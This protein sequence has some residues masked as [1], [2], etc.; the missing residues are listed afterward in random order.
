MSAA[1][2]RE[3]EF[4]DSGKLKIVSS[5]KDTYIERYTKM[6]RNLQ[7]IA[8][9]LVLLITIV[10][11]LNLLDSRTIL[12]ITAIGFITASF[13]PSLLAI[14]GFLP[15]RKIALVI[16]TLIYGIWILI[17]SVNFIEIIIMMA[18]LIFFFEVTRMII[19]IEPFTKGITSISEGGV[20]YHSAITIRRYFAFLL[21][22]GGILFGGSTVIGIVGWFT[23]KQIQGDIIFSIFLIAS[24]VLI[25]VITQ[26]TLTPD[27]QKFIIQKR[28]QQIEDELT[29][30]HTKFS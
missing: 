3:I 26:R 14:F 24:L 1:E 25:L 16:S 7:L 18:V 6:R 8:L 21:K 27:M 30:S 17:L 22:F 4:V 23:F 20:Y 19:V 28:K 10:A 9:I 5:V 29:K 11:P 15:G 2:P 12:D 13:V